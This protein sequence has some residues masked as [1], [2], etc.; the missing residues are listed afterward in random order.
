MS[1][2][3]HISVGPSANHISSHLLNL[4]GLAATIGGVDGEDNGDESLCDP[5]VTHDIA[6]D[7]DGSHSTGRYLYVPRVLF[8]DGRNSFDEWGTVGSNSQLGYN[9]QN[10]SSSDVVS[11][12]E[13][14]VNVWDSN[15]KSLIFGQQPQQKSEQ[16]S[17][18]DDSLV[19]FRNAASALGLSS[20]SRFAATSQNHGREYNDN[21]RHVQWNDEEDED[22]YG[23]EE[24][25]QEEKRRRL[26]IINQRNQMI[27]RELQES[28][29]D[30]WEQTFYPS[31]SD[32]D[33]IDARMPDN[34]TAL[35]QDSQNVNDSSTPVQSDV[36][37]TERE[38]RW[39]DYFMPPRP[40]SVR[41]QIALPFDTENKD[42]NSYAM[43]Y[44]SASSIGGGN[45]S[46]GGLSQSWREHSMSESLRKMLEGCDEVKGFNL[47]VDGG[48]YT[49]SSSL[50][51]GA[52]SKQSINPGGSVYAGLATSILEE[53]H[54]ECRSAGR[55]AALVDPLSTLNRKVDASESTQIHEFRRQLN[56]GMALHGLSSSADTFLPLSLNGAHRALCGDRT[57]SQNR[58]T[59]EGSAAVALALETSTLYYRLRRN[60][61]ASSS[62]PRSR[63]GIQS[64]FYQCV[65]GSDLGND[66]NEPYASAPSLTYH[67]FLACTR[68]SSD[69]RRSIL[70]LD[71]MLRPLS[72][73]GKNHNIGGAGGLPPHV[74]TSLFG[75]GGGV[76]SNS[77]GLL[78][79]RL[80]KGSSLEQMQ[81]DQDRNYRSRRS[82]SGRL[83][84]P[85]EWLEDNTT[86]CVGGRGMLYSLS[87]HVSPFGMRSDHHHFAL[88]SAL[89]PTF[90][91]ANGIAANSCGVNVFLRPMMESMGV[92]YRPGVSIGVVVKDTVVDLTGVESYWGS[93][94]RKVQ[95]P[96]S[97]SPQNVL[98]SPR[99]IASHAP[100]LSVLGNS[101]RTYPRLRAI[102]T[103]FDD[104]LHSR[105]NMGYLTRDAMAGVV[106]EK[107]DCEEALEFCKELVDVYEPPLGSGLVDGEDENDLDNAYFDEH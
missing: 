105:K 85:G 99:E 48:R 13:G 67:E 33:V 27:Q 44:Q 21:S 97:N 81:L 31:T 95:Y 82:V 24:R 25:M 4:Y 80:M 89:R 32:S 69:N 86:E 107:D 15:D 87:G 75:F 39:H 50:D 93:V 52:N 79:Q 47:L 96:A 5:I 28:M 29:C 77:L 30:A 61:A 51:D 58:M 64:G 65:G 74:L 3:I 40:L 11:S 22:Y 8:V 12:W 56:A 2:T 106:P 84:G 14:D 46:F 104:S 62:G 49:A 18:V 103:G 7:R 19:K 78:H 38:I 26:E 23:D 59:F 53:L 60:R 98:P 70:E 100:I 73:P 34:S 9:W 83:T 10:Y 88:S 35:P 63:I 6:N 90:S 94:F 66:T 57:V 17:Y 76:E 16:K 55:W 101:T 1:S 91:D 72:Y 71:A 45:S 92:K 36:S 68:S 20:Y 37:I 42:C 43:G 41:Y 54:D 102:S